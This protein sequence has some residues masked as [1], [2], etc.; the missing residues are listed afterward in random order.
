MWS[1]DVSQLVGVTLS[2]VENLDDEEL[3]FTAEDGRKWRMYHEQD[4][5]ESVRLEDIA[6]D[7]EDLVGTPIV[8][9]Y[10]DSST[11]APEAR[12]DERWGDSETWTFYRFRTIKGSVTLRWYGTSNGYYSE[13]V[14]FCEIK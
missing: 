8:E 1:G 11:E 14:Y 6:G 12:V 4:C 9:A 10:E 5:C 2:K 7:L 13:S 3:I